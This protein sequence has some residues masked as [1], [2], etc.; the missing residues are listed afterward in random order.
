MTQAMPSSEHVPPHRPSQ[1]PSRP[2]SGFTSGVAATA[3]T[4]GLWE[5]DAISTR[6]V[7]VSDIVDD[8][9]MEVGPLIVI[10]RVCMKTALRR[11]RPHA[12]KPIARRVGTRNR[13]E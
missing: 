1:S 4:I 7:K 13:D 11:N 12:R 2:V 5:T 10:M 9:L 6:S 8:A 3:S